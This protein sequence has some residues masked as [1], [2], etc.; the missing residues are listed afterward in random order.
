M[1]N[2]NVSNLSLL[3]AGFQPTMEAVYQVVVLT[4]DYWT[5]S[6]SVSHFILDELNSKGHFHD[7]LVFYIDMSSSVVVSFILS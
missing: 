4:A 6:F 3:Y 1:V 7:F 2:R 5:S